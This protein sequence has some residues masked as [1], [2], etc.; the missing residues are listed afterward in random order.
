M[1]KV[2]LIGDSIR[3]GAR[4]ST[5]GGEVSPGYECFVREKLQDIAEVYAPN[6]NCRFAQHTLRFLNKWAADAP[7]EEIDVVHWNNGLWDALRLYGDEPLTP[8]DMYVALLRRIYKHIQMFF[9]RATIVFATSTAVLEAWQ[10][11]HF[12]RLNR[13]IE[14]YNRAAAE[15]MQ[16]L[17]VPIDDL[18]TLSAGLDES[19]HRDAVHYNE[20]GCRLLADQVAKVCRE[21]L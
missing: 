6:E 10:K 8:V 21:Y 4:A 3:Y 16:E 5:P 15:L 12:C 2:Y 19:F 14:Q 18:Y 13:E 1:K 20:A 9:P 11:P 17:N 7:A